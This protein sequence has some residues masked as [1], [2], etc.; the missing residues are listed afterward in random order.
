MRSIDLINSVINPEQASND[1]V[2][3]IKELSQKLDDI[4]NTIDSL[5]EAIKNKPVKNPKKKN[6]NDTAP[7]GDAGSN[8]KEE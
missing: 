3:S 5:L 2:L 4:S 8:D 7:E 1:P 6:E